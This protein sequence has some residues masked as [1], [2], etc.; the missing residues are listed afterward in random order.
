MQ[1]SF[2]V[3]AKSGYMCEIDA[4]KKLCEQHNNILYIITLKLNETD[5]KLEEEIERSKVLQDTVKR[6]EFDQMLFEKKFRVQV[7]KNNMF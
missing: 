6:L 5:L 1:R 7:E 4:L 2:A 3:F